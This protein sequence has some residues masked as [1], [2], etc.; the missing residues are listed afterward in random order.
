MVHLPRI[1][2]SGGAE[3]LLSQEGADVIKRRL[4]SPQEGKVEG[5]TWIISTPHMDLTL[6]LP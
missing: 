2:V 6:R 5:K 1:V 4:S 3:Q